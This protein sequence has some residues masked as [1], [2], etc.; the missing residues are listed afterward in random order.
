VRDQ[1]TGTESLNL[2][3]DSQPDLV[4][5]GMDLVRNIGQRRSAQS[6]VRGV[7]AVSFVWPSGTCGA[8]TVTQADG[9]PDDP[10]GGMKPVI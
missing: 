10:I 8:R 4:K 1:S 7:S 5:F 9:C 6:I 2:L 3:A